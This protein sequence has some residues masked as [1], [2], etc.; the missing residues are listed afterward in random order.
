MV[1]IFL[2]EHSVKIVIFLIHS[3]PDCIPLQNLNIVNVSFMLNVSE[4]KCIIN[5]FYL[6]IPSMPQEHI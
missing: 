1:Q 3:E 2:K 5:I 6:N 4:I